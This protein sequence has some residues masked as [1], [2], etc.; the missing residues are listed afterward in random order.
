MPAANGKVASLK[1]HSGGSGASGGISRGSGG[2]GSG[3][4]GGAGGGGGGG[5][6]GGRGGGGG[7]GLYGE[8]V[9]GHGMNANAAVRGDANAQRVVRSTGL[10]PAKP[11]KPAMDEGSMAAGVYTRPLLSST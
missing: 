9:N 4:S 2:G 1:R 5:G 3:S 10:G 6:A 11:R 8:G 7:N